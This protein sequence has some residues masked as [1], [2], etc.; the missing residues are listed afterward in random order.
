MAVSIDSSLRLTTVMGTA[1]SW[2]PGFSAEMAGSFHTVM[3][4]LKIFAIV[5]PSIVRSS[6]PESWY[7]IVTGWT[8][9]GSCRTSHPGTVSSSA[10]SGRSVTAMSVVPSRNS[11]MPAPVPTGS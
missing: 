7:G 8:T 5:G 11:W 10:R 4:P 2:A 1:G 6:T 9:S 3:A